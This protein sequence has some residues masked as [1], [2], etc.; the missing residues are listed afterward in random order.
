VTVPRVACV[1]PALNAAPAL[2][3]VVAGLRGAL[4]EPF[5]VV[6]DDGSLDDT[7]SVGRDVADA[8]MR[9]ERNRGKGAA[10]RAGFGIA[11]QTG[12][13]VVITVDADGQHDPAF[14][15][16]LVAA[17]A[18][19]D[20]VIG[21]RDRSGPLMPRGRR[22]TN[23]LSA[24]A[25]SRCVGQPIADAQSG[26]RALRAEV[27][28]AI[29][30]RGDRYEY[31]TDFLIRTARGGHRIGFVPIP[32]CYDAVVPSQFRPLRDSARIIGTLW[33]FN[34]NMAY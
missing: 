15:P 27:L 4:G 29:D 8:T 25:V 6:V 13:S 19:Y 31:E 3:D 12:A 5:V 24:A 20:L 18:T 33:R 23:A 9:F 30:A 2:R 34:M 14:A 11:L 28:R 17:T 16:A 10:L 7:F 1:I 26:F 21:A 22:L 32:T